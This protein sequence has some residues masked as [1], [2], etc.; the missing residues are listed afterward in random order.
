MNST[1]NSKV[2]ALYLL[3]ITMPYMEDESLQQLRSTVWQD[4]LE[5]LVQDKGVNQRSAQNLAANDN[6]IAFPEELWENAQRIMI[7]T[8]DEP[9][10]SVVNGVKPRPSGVGKN[11]HQEWRDKDEEWAVEEELD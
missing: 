2:E 1:G 8:R 7:N 3:L 6:D 4:T 5:R 9:L 10:R 11:D